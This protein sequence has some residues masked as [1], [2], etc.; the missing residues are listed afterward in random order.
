MGMARMACLYF[1]FPITMLQQ[2]MRLRDEL[3]GCCKEEDPG[4]STCSTASGDR[5]YLICQIE[6]R[7]SDVFELCAGDTAL[8]WA[9]NHW[10]S[11]AS[12]DMGY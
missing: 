11:R 4:L 2:L 8:W 6:L 9:D 3:G 10:F 1:F 5:E 12:T 7:K